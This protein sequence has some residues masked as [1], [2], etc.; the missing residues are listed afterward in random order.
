MATPR[1]INLSTREGRS[2]GFYLR[3][4]RGEEGHLIRNLEPGG[5]AELA[6]IKDGDRILRVNGVFVDRKEHSQVVDM[7][8]N[9]GTTV[10]FHILDKASYQEAVGA[11]VDLSNPQPRPAQAQ[12][13]MNG[14]AGSTPKPRL[15][16][17]TKAKSGYGFSL[18]STLGE[19]GIFMINLTPGG[20][21]ERAGVKAQDRV[22]EVNGENVE[23][24]THEQIVEKVKASGASVVF[25]LAD[26]EM[27]S[28]CRNRK[29]K[30]AAELAT[31]KL[32]PHKPRIADMA[33]GSDGYGFYLRADPEREGHFI[34]DIDRGSPAEAAGLRDMDRL[35]AV[36]GQEVESLGHEQVVD[37]I[38][39]CGESCSLLVVAEETN[40]MYKMAG[41]S[42]LLY[43]KEV[44]GSPPASPKGGTPTP[45]PA[46]TPPPALA[47]P[48]AEDYKPKLCKLEK[49]AD[50]FGFHLSGIHGAPGQ[51]LKEVMKGGVADRAGLRDGDVVVEV[52]GQNVEDCTHEEVVE[53]IRRCGGSLVLLVAEKQ[54][55]NFFKA[56]KI[57]VNTQL[58]EQASA[59]TP[60]TPGTPESS[61]TPETPNT[62][63]TSATPNNETSNTPEPPTTPETPNTP[64]TSN[65]PEPPATPETSNTPE[66]PATPET[67]D[68][69]LGQ[70]REEE[71]EKE[72][73]E[74]EEK[75]SEKGAEQ[76]EEAGEGQQEEAGR[77]EEVNS[78]AAPPSQSEP[79]VRKVSVSSVA[80]SGPGEDERL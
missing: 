25:L 20:V 71:E 50:G 43:W 22:V 77:E 67:P 18:K 52:G 60:E 49:T 17:L 55:Y 28:Y 59:D 5:P 58:L 7:V 30:L 35:V 80:S 21:A 1:V 69:T 2:F 34:K 33:K 36:N 66:I 44:R 57:P 53:K 24:A 14:V 39:Q 54:A 72:E 64:E 46:P 37:R 62:P 4:E 8:K 11:G 26:E 48:I 13:V 29:L 31:C 16:F 32:L 65:T 12:P 38:R 70:G 3:E 73:E 61:D 47:Q 41:V 23:D 27:D 19:K 15:C 45:E 40:N 79:G 63:E 68:T 76:G 6:G 9:S 78:P 75:R 42:P 51:Y 56:R 10:T 74:E